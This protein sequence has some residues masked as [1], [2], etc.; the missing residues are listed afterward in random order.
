MLTKT[1]SVVG[2]EAGGGQLGPSLRPAPR[3]LAE[4]RAC[5]NMFP[6][7]L[8]R[9]CLRSPQRVVLMQDWDVTSFSLFIDYQAH[10]S[11]TEGLTM[12]CLTP[13]S[14]A[15]VEGSRSPNAVSLY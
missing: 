4:H 15:E 12:V 8:P 7:R 5:R 6:H 13:R 14:V 9:L 2:A 10:H 3:L 1:C 11:F